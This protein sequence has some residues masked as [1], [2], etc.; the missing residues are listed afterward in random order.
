MHEP[1]EP[2]QAPKEQKIGYFAKHWQ[3]KH[4]LS[5]SYWINYW[6]LS[7]IFTAGL[8]IWTVS[9]EN[10]N[11]VTYSR[12]SLGLIVVVYLIIYPWQI[13]GL[14]RSANNTIINTGKTFWPRVVKFLIIIGLLGGI[15]SELRDK[16]VYQDLYYYAFELSTQKNY[17]V[18]VDDN[19]L[20][21]DGDFDYGLSKEVAKKLKQ[22]QSIEVVL[23]NSDGGLLFEARELSELILLNSLNTYTVESCLSACT[24]AFISGQERYIHKDARLGFHQYSIVSPTT[25]ADKAALQSLVVD[26]QQDAKFFQKRGVDKAFTNYM[27][28]YNSDDMW[29][30]KTNILEYYG[31]VDGVIGY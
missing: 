5:K 21:V 27:Y 16:S 25:R 29:Y 9:A 4:S 17:Q 31:V 2:A 3:G 18:W 20:V 22:N 13:I 6:L 12:L 30:P 26:Q 23:L 10:L 14:W 28:Q 15:G 1:I 19:I 7:V 8:A 24:I 11:P